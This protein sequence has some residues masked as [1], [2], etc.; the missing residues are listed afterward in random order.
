MT[1]DPTSGYVDLARFRETLKDN[2]RQYAMV[3]IV[4]LHMKLEYF[5]EADTLDQLMATIS[6]TNPVCHFYGTT[7]ASR[8]ILEGYEEI[9]SH[10]SHSLPAGWHLGEAHYHDVTSSDGSI[11]AWGTWEYVVTG[12][13][14][15]RIP[16]SLTDK[17]DDPDARYRIK[18]NMAVF[19]PFD[20]SDPPRMLGE[21][22][23]RDDCGATIKKL[24]EDEP[25]LMHSDVSQ[26]TFRQALKDAGIAA[27]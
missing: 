2:P 19:C 7:A 14:H 26:D 16:L 3:S 24:S 1:L 18:Y 6:L 22:I 4:M 8:A 17:I 20:R 23:F 10:Y 25:V 11:G 9:R 5:N 15:G 12:T 13:E 27:E 21:D